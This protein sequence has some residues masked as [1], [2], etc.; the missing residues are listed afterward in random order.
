MGMD[1]H[2]ELAKAAFEL[3]KK[4]AKIRDMRKDSILALERIIG[5]SKKANS[6]LE[7]IK[8]KALVDNARDIGVPVRQIKLY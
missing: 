1:K 6:G 3:L 2:G 7:F 8:V 5:L 4:A